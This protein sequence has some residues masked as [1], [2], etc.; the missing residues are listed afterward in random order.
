MKWPWSKV[1]AECLSC[2]YWRGER[3]PHPWQGDCVRHAPGFGGGRTDAL[4]V[5]PETFHT[6]WC[7]DYE[8]AA[9]E[10]GR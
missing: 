4:R 2:R 6:D 9:Q 8:R 5:W 7:G 10:V 3:D 1:R